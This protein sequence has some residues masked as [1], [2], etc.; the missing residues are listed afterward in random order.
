M[1]N[2]KDS[3]IHFRNTALASF[4]EHHHNL[5]LFVPNMFYLIINCIIFQQLISVTADICTTL[6][7][8]LAVE[9]YKLTDNE[10]TKNSPVIR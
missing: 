4:N 10:D 2:N 6:M 7:R 5:N 9:H 1:T 3:M 8:A